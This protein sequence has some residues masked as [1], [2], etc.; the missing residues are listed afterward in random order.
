MNI[1]KTIESLNNNYGY[2]IGV[3]LIFLSGAEF[4]N[5]LM[6]VPMLTPTLAKMC[7]EKGELCYLQNWYPLLMLSTVITKT[8]PMLWAGF[9]MTKK[10]K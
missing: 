1:M 9:I 5:W 6:V 3:I 4:F 10:V 8:L 2:Y 7:I